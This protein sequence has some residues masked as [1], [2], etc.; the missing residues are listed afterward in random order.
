MNCYHTKQK[1]RLL[2]VIQSKNKEFTVK[3]V[4]EGLN[5]EIGLTTIYRYI[6]KLVKDGR[7]LQVVGDNNIT[8]YQY[9]ELCDKENHFYLKC[10]V[11]GKL[12]HVDCDCVKDLSNHILNVHGFKLNNHEFIVNGICDICSKECEL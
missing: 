6:D 12:I 5:K 11:C 9:K 10:D 4:Y 1:D 3:E 8:Y 7:V 2:K